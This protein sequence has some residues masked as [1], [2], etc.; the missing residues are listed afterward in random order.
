MA[1]ARIAEAGSDHERVSH[2]ATFL[3][4]KLAERCALD[5]VVQHNVHAILASGGQISPDQLAL[6]FYG[7][8]RSLEKPRYGK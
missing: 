6:G 3:E 8:A 4:C 1:E 5:S 7:A 2:L